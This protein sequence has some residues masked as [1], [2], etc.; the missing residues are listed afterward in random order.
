MVQRLFVTVIAEKSVGFIVE[1]EVS[2]AQ[3]A[4]ATAVA[5]GGVKGVLVVGLVVDD[6][7]EEPLL[8]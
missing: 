3:E 7:K 8:R 5:V 1:I 2:D 6:A 4:A